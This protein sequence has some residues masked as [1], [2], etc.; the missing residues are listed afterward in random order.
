MADNK[1]LEIDLDEELELLRQELE[2]N[3][4]IYKQVKDQYDAVCRSKSSGTFKFI[5]DQTSNLM[6]IR[7][8]RVSVI[9][10]MINI[11]RIKLDASIKELSLNKEDGNENE[12]AIAIAKEIYNNMKNDSREGSVMNL[13]RTPEDIENEKKAKENGVELEDNKTEDSD[14]INKRMIELNKK[15]LEA[16]KQ[17]D[18]KER[19][20]F[21]ACDRD[22]NLYAVSEDGTEIIEGAELPDFEI[23]IEIDKLTGLEIAK[24]QFGDEVEL[25]EIE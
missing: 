4:V 1:K 17:K 21:I 25:I 13:L 23:T 19:G 18:I 9:K 11:K 3:E 8:S 22:G 10:E 5:T 16:Q 7:N 15:K 24:N 2:E 14:I 12:R 6:N 20:Y